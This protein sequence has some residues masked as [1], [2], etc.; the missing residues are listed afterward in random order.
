MVSVEHGRR[1]KERTDRKAGALCRRGKAEGTHALGLP[2]AR[3]RKDS[4][5]RKSRFEYNHKSRHESVRVSMEKKNAKLTLSHL[6]LRSSC[7]S[8]MPARP[9]DIAELI[10]NQ[11]SVETT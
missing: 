2:L 9:E 7:R 4:D 5:R 1:V 10:T 3:D 11:S 6:E 8:S